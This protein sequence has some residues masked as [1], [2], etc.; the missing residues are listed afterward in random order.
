MSTITIIREG[1][2]LIQ[3]T[4]NAMSTLKDKYC[5][6]GRTCEDLATLGGLFFVA[7]FMYVALKPLGGL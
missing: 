4:V 3:R 5:P 2:S 1:K 6:D 7:W